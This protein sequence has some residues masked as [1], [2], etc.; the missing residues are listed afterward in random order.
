MSVVQSR[1]VY[2]EQA[3]HGVQCTLAFQWSVEEISYLQAADEKKN[4]NTYLEQSVQQIDLLWQHR[5]LTRRIK[6]ID[7]C[8][9]RTSPEINISHARVIEI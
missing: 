1:S 2:N 8:L 6:D 5:Q 9:G 7:R 3:H 4:A